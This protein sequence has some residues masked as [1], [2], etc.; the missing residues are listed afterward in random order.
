MTKEDTEQGLILDSDTN[1][2]ISSDDKSE[3]DEA[4]AAAGKNSNASRTWDNK[5]WSKPRLPWNSGGIHPL[6]E[7]LSK[8]MTQGALHVHKNFTITVFLVI[9]IEMTHLFVTKS[10]KYHES[11]S[12]AIYCD[13]HDHC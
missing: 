3:L 4:T 12:Q 2:A 5:M 8:L 1:V 10:N 13:A 9:F 7:G 11:Y 6:T